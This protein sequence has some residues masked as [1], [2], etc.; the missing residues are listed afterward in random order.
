MQKLF[1]QFV[2]E[3]TYLKNVTPATIQW[4]WSS[5]R[6]FA[7]SLVECEPSASAL[8]S[9]VLE[10]IAQLKADGVQ[11]VSI[12]TYLR[13]INAFFAWA[14]EEGHVSARVRIPRL[15]AD[16]KLIATLTPAHIQT[17]VAFRPKTFS[18]QRSHALACLLLDT[19]LR[20]N[21]ALTLIRED[22]DLDN[23][24]L[25][26]RGKG[27][28]HRAVPFSFAM[29]KVLYRWLQRHTHSLVFPCQNGNPQSQR[30]ALRDFKAFGS[31]LGIHGVRFS[32][33]TLRHTFATNYVRLGGSVFHLQRV[34]GHSSVTM[35]RHYCELSISDI[36]QVH[37]RVSSLSSVG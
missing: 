16:Q 10:G 28:K 36:Q 29:R 25:K 8:K 20:A 22:V 17:I 30:N 14:H 31:K 32:F 7:Q 33:H 21:E 5:W 2:K 6:P 12:N 3:R 15:K 27:R 4:Y 18:D 35:T 9:A 37:A 23:L 34:L 19:G 24:L 26:V 1:E 13:A 11:A